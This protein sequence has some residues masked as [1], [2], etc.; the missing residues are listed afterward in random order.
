MTDHVKDR[1][2]NLVKPLKA[3]FY[4]ICVKRGGF[5]Y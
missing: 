5:N 2:S 4:F 3:Q 1:G